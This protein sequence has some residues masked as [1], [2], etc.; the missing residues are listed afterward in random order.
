MSDIAIFHQRSGPSFEEL[1]VGY[2]HLPEFIA[3]VAI[4]ACQCPTLSEAAVVHIP[5]RNDLYKGGTASRFSRACC[6][7][8]KASLATSNQTPICLVKEENLPFH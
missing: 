1:A 5:K 6:A 7:E 3:A 8:H 4:D 2:L